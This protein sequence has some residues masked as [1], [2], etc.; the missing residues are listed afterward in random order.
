MI[1]STQHPLTWLTCEYTMT[2]PE[3]ASY[4]IARPVT[5]VSPR[6]RESISPLCDMDAISMSP[7]V[8]SIVDW[9]W[10]PP[11]AVIWQGKIKIDIQRVKVTKGQRV[12]WSKVI[13]RK[14]EFLSRISWNIS[15]IIKI[16]F[17]HLLLTW[18][19]APIINVMFLGSRRK[20]GKTWKLAYMTK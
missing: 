20:G 14:L 15:S 4:P 13:V 6:S 9:G 16:F 5:I 12:K 18:N 11:Y 3:S 19:I 2:F 8:N 17:T 1:A 10:G 7:I